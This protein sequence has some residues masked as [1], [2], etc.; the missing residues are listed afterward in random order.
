MNTTRLS[1]A[2]LLAAI[3]AVVLATGAALTGCATG[4]TL[5]GS[6]PIDAPT[7][8]VT[9]PARGHWAEQDDHNVIAYTVLGTD[10]LALAGQ[11]DAPAVSTHGRF[12]LAPGV[13][14]CVLPVG[15]KSHVILFHAER[16]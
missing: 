8:L 16:P 11:S 7:A 13:T 14:L 5:H 6:V 15:S 4:G 2:F 12:L 1:I 9:G 10:C 3:V